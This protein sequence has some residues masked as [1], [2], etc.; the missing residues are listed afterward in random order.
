MLVSTWRTSGIMNYDQI[1]VQ[2]EDVYD[3]L[4]I[5]YPLFIFLLL[6]DQSSG[7]GKMTQ[8]A[9]FIN[10]M[11]VKFGGRQEKLRTSVT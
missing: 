5:K 6:L 3:I 8:G 1:C 11:S 9:Q 4:A 2:V 10:K 7:H